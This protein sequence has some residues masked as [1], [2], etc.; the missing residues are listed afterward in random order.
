MRKKIGL[1]MSNAQLHIGNHYKST[2]LATVREIG[3]T[4]LGSMFVRSD[5]E[6]KSDLWSNIGSMFVRTSSGRQGELWSN[7]ECIG[8]FRGERSLI[9]VP[10]TTVRDGDDL[11]RHKFLRTVRVLIPA[12]AYICGL[13]CSRVSGYPRISVQ[14]VSQAGVSEA[15]HTP[16]P[17]APLCMNLKR[18]RTSSSE[19]L[20]V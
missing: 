10:N 20:L 17:S 14:D 1:C 16:S 4:I 12:S 9:I 19:S 11:A 8:H 15:G 3:N 18:T 7:M 13:Q 6:I 5:M 2:S